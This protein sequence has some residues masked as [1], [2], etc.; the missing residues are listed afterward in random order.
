[1]DQKNNSLGNKRR[2][3]VIRYAPLLIWICVIFF[4]SSSQGSMSHT[5]L[6]IRPILEFLFPSTSEA[7]LLIYHGYIRKCA[8]FAVY[9]VLGVLAVRAF[10]TRRISLR[11]AAAL[12]VVALVASADEFNQSFEVSRTGS[13]WDVLLDCFGGSVGIC[14]ARLFT[15]VN[16]RAVRD[17]K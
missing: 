8:H 16:R 13:A 6:F 10:R 1:M 7:T 9:F 14:A 17:E 2:S 3:S 15:I 11:V 12:L 5:S 4:L